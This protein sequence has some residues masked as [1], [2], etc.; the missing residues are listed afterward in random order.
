VVYTPLLAAPPG[1]ATLLVRT[2]GDGAALTGAVREALRQ[3]DGL[4]PLDRA[5]SL[6]LATRDATWAARVSA[7]L[8]NTVSLSA[9][10]L[11]VTGLYAVV[12]H[13]TARR[14]REIG[15]RMALGADGMAIARLVVGTVRGAV[16]L[17]LVLGVLGVA[18]WNRLFEPAGPGAQMISPT[19]VAAVVAALVLTVVAG[20]L[21][22]AGRAARIAPGEA[23]RRE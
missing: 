5:R 19:S 9:F 11:A 6:A 16:G 4:V 21:L 14:R 12:S 7:T 17:G 10:A 15:L 20:C 1:T 8:A 3:L 13:R 18:A 23:L 2:G 22:P